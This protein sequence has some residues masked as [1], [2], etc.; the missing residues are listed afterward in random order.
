M[1]K[2]LSCFRL[3][4]STVSLSVMPRRKRLLVLSLGAIGVAA[5]ICVLGWKVLYRPDRMIHGRLESEWIRSLT[6]FAEADVEF[7][8][9]G[10]L[11][12]DAV[13]IL[14]E[15]ARYRDGTMQ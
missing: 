15:A 5:S 6:N 8:K 3:Q 11:G 1:K 12:Q 10:T 14:V 7:K 9:W 13:P 2:G 4:T